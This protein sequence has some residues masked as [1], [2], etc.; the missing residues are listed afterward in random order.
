MNFKSYIYILINLFI[1][2]LGN[3]NT[4]SKSILFSGNSQRFRRIVENIT[5]EIIHHAIIFTSV[6]FNNGNYDLDKIEIDLVKKIASL[7]KTEGIITL[8]PVNPIAVKRSLMKDQPPEFERI[9]RKQY[10]E[11]DPYSLLGFF[12]N[13]QDTK[14]HGLLTGNK[15]RISRLYREFFEFESDFSVTAP[16]YDQNSGIR[17]SEYYKNV[18]KYMKNLSFV[19]QSAI[20][21][22]DSSQIKGTLDFNLYQEAPSSSNLEIEGLGLQDQVALLRC[23]P[24]VS[25]DLRVNSFLKDYSLEQPD[26][27]EKQISI[28]SSL[29]STCYRSIHKLNIMI[30]YSEIF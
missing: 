4:P 2:L 29:M 1:S 11:G 8:E 23:S 19:C 21:Q 5:P 12:A 30:Y 10:A 3:I 9:S 28:F 7:K 24:E 6:A 27:A 26:A 17:K 22:F 14:K 15:L 25:E 18:L 20:I 13:F 16:F